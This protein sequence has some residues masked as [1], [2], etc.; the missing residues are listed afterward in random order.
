MFSLVVLSPREILKQVFSARFESMI[1]F[2]P[3]QDLK[4]AQEWVIFTTKTGSKMF[5]SAFSRK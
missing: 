2:V 1:H 3:P 5:K 4:S